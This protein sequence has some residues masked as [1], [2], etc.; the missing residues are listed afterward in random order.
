[1]PRVGYESEIRQARLTAILRA[2]HPIGRGSMALISE[3]LRSNVIFISLSGI[4]GS[5]SNKDATMTIGL[6]TS[7][8][9]ES[10]AAGSFTILRCNKMRAFFGGGRIKFGLDDFAL[11]PFCLNLVGA[12]LSIYDRNANESTR[13]EYCVFMMRLLFIS[14]FI[15]SF[16]PIVA[17]PVGQSDGNT[18]DLFDGGSSDLFSSSLPAVKSSD[19]NDMFLE[20]PSLGKRALQSFSYGLL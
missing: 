16:A 13:L 6:Y 18:L 15:F 8:V 11:V 7:H 1:M 2:K 10:I 5:A 4:Y 17:I 3:R 12:S 20:D 9:G 19:S 14:Q